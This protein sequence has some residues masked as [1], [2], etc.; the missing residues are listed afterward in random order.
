MQQDSLIVAVFLASLVFWLL[1]V[2]GVL[3]A[4]H[5]SRVRH[6]RSEMVRQWQPALVIALVFQAGVGLSGMG[7]FNPMGLVVF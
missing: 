5:W 2:V 1:A 4:G 7:L 3:V 6:F